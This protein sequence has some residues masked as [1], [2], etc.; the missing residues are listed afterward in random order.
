MTIAAIIRPSLGAVSA[1][2]L[3]VGLAGCGQD[4]PEVTV[5][6]AAGPPATADTPRRLAFVTNLPADFWNIARAGVEA[7]DGEL[8]DY[9]VEFRNG[10]GTAARQKEI[11]ED[12][13]VKGV[14]G[15]AISP[16]DAGNQTAMIDRAADKALVVCQDSD[17]PASK[18]AFYLGTD[19]I[20]AGRAAG[21]LLK[22]A[23][24]DGGKVMVFVGKRDQRNAR[25]RFQGLNEAVQGSRITILDLRADDGDRARA[26]ANAAD[27]LVKHPDLAGM[28]GLWAYNAPAILH[29]LKDAGRLRGI[30][31]V[32][33]DEEDET[34]AGI[35]S[36][37]VHGSVVQQPYEFGYR[38]VHL[39]ARHLA[40]DTA[41]VPSDKLMFVPTEVITAGNIAAFRSRLATMRGK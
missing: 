9:I 7:A 13:L 33:F 5:S 1:L 10:D 38:S 22:Q 25:E 11:V 8:P 6:G 29:A 36:G 30:K 16:V 4:A 15:I 35:A 40:G 18:R 12:V 17:A 34:L 27:T 2:F 21:E 41:F 20:A 28:V 31:V 32:A 24:P 3:V 39:M 23:L 19:N 37:A 14:V 26:K